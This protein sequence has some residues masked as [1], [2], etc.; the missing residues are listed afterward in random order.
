MSELENRNPHL[1]ETLG[2]ELKQGW[3][4]TDRL[5]KRVES[6]AIL[7]HRTKQFTDWTDQAHIEAFDKSSIKVLK[8][9]KSCGDYLIFRNYLVSKRARLIGA[10]TCQQHLLCAFCAAR[11]GVKNSA[12]YKEKTN[13]LQ[14]QN[15]D[16][17]L[18]FL[19][20]TVKNGPDL[21]ERFSHLRN[22]MKTLL[23]HRNNQAIGHR[24]HETEMAK[25]SGGV[26]AYEFKRGS[27]ENLWHPHIHMIALLPKSQK[28][29]IQILKDEW[30]KITEDSQVINIEY[31]TNDS[32]FLEVFAYALKFSEMEHSDRW[33]AS[34][35]LRRERL[36]SSFGELRGVEVSE[37]LTDD[38]LLTDEP[39]VDL[40][41]TWHVGR[42]YGAPS[43]LSEKLT[44]DEVFNDVT[45]GWSEEKK[46]S[47]KAWEIERREEA[48]RQSAEL[49]R[50]A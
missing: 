38:I 22:S 36:I 24:K 31:C 12:A 44:L 7:K 25:L 11:R 6:F 42:G 41:F 2:G 14:V 17:D 40:L 29:D 19:T 34:Q 33:M 32:A 13:I 30:L 47:F 10:C 9:V 21:I 1:S 26:F 37:E 16:L 20:F 39:F 49:R 35:L 15:P 50:A 23:R 3:D 18:V 46:N 43:V 28:I 27:I 48:V 5:E 4:S 45:A 8:K